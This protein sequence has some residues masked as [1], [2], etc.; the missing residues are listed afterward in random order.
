MSEFKV[1]KEIYSRNVL[2]IANAAYDQVANMCITKETDK[3]YIVLVKNEK[4]EV[5]LIKKEYMNYLIGI[6]GCR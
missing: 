6:M 3:Y 1:N 5:D 2:E 4:A